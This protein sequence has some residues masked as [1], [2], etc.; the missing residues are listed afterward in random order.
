MVYIDTIQ[1]VKCNGVIYH[2]TSD[3]AAALTGGF[4]SAG[5][6]TGEATTSDSDSGAAVG[7]GVADCSKE[8]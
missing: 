6:G 1:H 5:A 2:P 4:L 7:S 8:G 3:D